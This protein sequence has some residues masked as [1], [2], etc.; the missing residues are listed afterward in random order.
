MFGDDRNDAIALGL[1]LERM[2]IDKQMNIFLC[3]NNAQ[4]PVVVIERSRPCISL[5]SGVEFPDDVAYGWIRRKVNLASEMDADFRA[6]VTAQEGTVL[7]QRY[8]QAEPCRRDGCA[9]SCYS[10]A[11]HDQVKIAG[12]LRLIR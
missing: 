12:D 9:G 4:L 7:Y 8:L 11:D 5:V 10:A 2:H 3:L 1:N 6:I